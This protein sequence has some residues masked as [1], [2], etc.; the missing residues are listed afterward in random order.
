MVCCLFNLERKMLRKNGWLHSSLDLWSSKR[1]EMWQDASLQ[2]LLTLGQDILL[3]E[4]AALRRQ[5]CVTSCGAIGSPIVVL[6]L[7][8]CSKFRKWSSIQTYSNHS[9]LGRNSTPPLDFFLSHM[10]FVSDPLHELKGTPNNNEHNKEW[11]EKKTSKMKRECDTC[12]KSDPWV[13]KTSWIAMLAAATDWFVDRC[14]LTEN[15]NTT[16]K[17]ELLEREI[18]KV[19]SIWILQKVAVEVGFTSFSLCLFC[20]SFVSGFPGHGLGGQRPGHRQPFCDRHGRSCR[21]LNAEK[22]WKIQPTEKSRSQYWLSW[23]QR[24]R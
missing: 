14:C 21:S 9:G 17:C 20:V 16:W 15:V 19:R 11:M 2:I 8:S 6:P 18:S 24:R 4:E 23:V 22:L 10:H 7:F 5:T 12:D 13:T 3:I 1:T